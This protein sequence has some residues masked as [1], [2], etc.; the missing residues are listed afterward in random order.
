MKIYDITKCLSGNVL[1]IGV[2]ENVTEIIKENDLITNCNLLN[3]STKGK[4]SSNKKHNRKKYS[5]NPQL[6]QY[7]TIK[8]CKR[9][10]GSSGLNNSE[11]KPRSLH[12]YPI[13]QV[14]YLSP[15]AIYF[16]GIPQA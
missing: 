11:K 5:N 3:S 8:K 4:T 13:K 15:K 1:G 16:Q 6:K 9:T 12:P 7:I 10:I 2:D 14:F